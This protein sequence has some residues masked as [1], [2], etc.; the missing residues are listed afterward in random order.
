[1]RIARSLRDFIKEKSNVAA[2]FG[3]HGGAG[4]SMYALSILDV[5][6]DHVEAGVA[7]M[8]GELRRAVKYPELDA[9][10]LRSLIGPRLEE[11]ASSLMSAAGLEKGSRSG[12]Y[13]Q[14]ESLIAAREAKIRE[15]IQFWLRQFDIGWDEAVEP[16]KLS[17]PPAK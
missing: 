7:V 3:S 6:D 11:L 5:V 17:R 13:T 16:E 8:L 4:S 1:M 14:L 9:F 12:G 10:E 15:N 2:K